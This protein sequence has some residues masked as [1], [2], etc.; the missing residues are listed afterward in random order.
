YGE[1]RRCSDDRRIGCFHHRSKPAPRG[2][3]GGSVSR[4]SP[5]NNIVTWRLQPIRVLVVRLPELDATGTVDSEH[6]GSPR[7][8]HGP[9]DLHDCRVT[10]HLRPA[11]TADGGS[12]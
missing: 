1:F 11:R 7:I 5:R 8:A 3:H 4:D 2:S 9:E 12:L 6:K 10:D